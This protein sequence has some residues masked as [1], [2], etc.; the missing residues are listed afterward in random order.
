M[1][2]DEAAIALLAL[3]GQY[4]RSLRL[5]F[6]TASNTWAISDLNTGLTLA[7]RHPST[8]GAFTAAEGQLLGRYP[9]SVSGTV[10]VAAPDGDANDRLR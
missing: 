5:S 9:D 1:T 6:Y 7:S 4:E 10:V 2:T 3:S 8:A